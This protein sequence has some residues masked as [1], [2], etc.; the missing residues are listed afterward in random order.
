MLVE[1]QIDVR[2]PD[3]DP[4]GIVHHGVYPLWFEIGR[5][6]YLSAA[7]YG[8]QLM[9]R[10]GINPAMV[11]LHVQYR[12]PIR[13]PGRVTVRTNCSLCQGKK[14]ALRYAVYPQGQTHPAA[15]GSSLHI[16]T[17]PAMQSLDLSQKPEVYGALQAAIDHQAVLILA[18]GRSRRMGR[19]KAQI[20][21]Q[22]QTLLDRAAAFWRSLLPEAHIY[23]A[24]G[25]QDH[26]VTLPQGVTPIYD[27]SPDQGPMGGL[28][29][30]FHTTR[31]ELLWVSAVDMP[32][33]CPEAVATLEQGRSHCE[34]VCVFTQN[35]RPEPLLGLYRSTCLPSIRGLLEAGN[36][37]MGNLLDQVSTT[38]V[39]LPA[40]SWVQNVN[41]PKELEALQENC[42]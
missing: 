37:R 6:D 23:V 27:L 41:T 13:F 16:W 15:L 17:G 3:C 9:N 30:A 4:M 14:F 31:E 7:G 34:D 11:D 38:L 8:Y 2:Y 18:G 40:Q 10:E 26:R 28:L 25:Q 24:L 5:L 35:G 12:S 39:P 36:G 20:R 29:A 42:P 32:A 33:L 21:L 19:D 22:G 1:S